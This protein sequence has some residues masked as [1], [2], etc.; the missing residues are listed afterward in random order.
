M[1]PEAGKLIWRVGGGR[2]HTVFSAACLSSSRFFMKGHLLDDFKWRKS[3]LQR[4][5]LERFS[6]SLDENASRGK[7]ITERERH[8]L[9]L[10]W[11]GLDSLS[12]LLFFKHSCPVSPPWL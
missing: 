10:R 11:K 5:T 12:P 3:I 8:Q 6:C 7:D 9:G 2:V 4:G 1:T